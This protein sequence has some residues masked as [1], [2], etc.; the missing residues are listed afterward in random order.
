VSAGGL[1]KLALAMSIPLDVALTP[2]SCQDVETAVVSGAEKLSEVEKLAGVT[3]ELST[4]SFVASKTVPGNT[5][6]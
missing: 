4:V 3:S 5:E 1:E 6:F 2:T